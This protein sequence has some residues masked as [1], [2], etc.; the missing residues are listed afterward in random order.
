MIDEEE[1]TNRFKQ[2]HPVIFK[3][4][5][6]RTHEGGG[7]LKKFAPWRANNEFIQFVQTLDEEHR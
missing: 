3:S 5:E 6:G 7:P 4:A 1:I 2:H